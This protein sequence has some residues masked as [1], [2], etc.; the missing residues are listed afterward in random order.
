MFPAQM[1]NSADPQVGF[2]KVLFQHSPIVPMSSKRLKGFICAIVL[3][4][5]AWM[6]FSAPVLALDYNRE[7][8][9]G[10][11]FSGQDLTDSEF[12][13]ANMRD[14]NLSH[15][16]LN[17]VRFFA[18]NLESANLEGADLRNSTLDAARL[19]RANLKDANLEG[20][21]AANAKFEGATIEGADF[22]DV[23]LRPDIQK[24]LCAIAKG[25]NPMTGRETR[26]TLYCD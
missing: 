12:T 19:T 1:S 18:T 8:L 9:I 25:T 23:A 17:G 21:F 22:T 13:K 11:D 4:F 3:L 24:M 10:M 16:N 6:S 2:K 26:E 5:A 7:S 14:T 20:A 15:T